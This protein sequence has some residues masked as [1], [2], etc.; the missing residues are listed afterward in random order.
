ML[1]ALMW[2]LRRLGVVKAHGR[3]TS[4]AFQSLRWEGGW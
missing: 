4:K 2:L 3:G 1:Q